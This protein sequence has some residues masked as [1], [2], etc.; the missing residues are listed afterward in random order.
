MTNINNLEIFT[1]DDAV[2]GPDSVLVLQGFNGQEEIQTFLSDLLQTNHPETSQIWRAPRVEL[3]TG[4]CETTIRRKVLRKE[5]P[6]PLDLGDRAKGWVASEVIA[7]KRTR[8]RRWVGEIRKP[9]ALRKNKPKP[10]ARNVAAASP[11]ELAAGNAEVTGATQPV[12][13]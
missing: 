5:F 6:A 3:E 1:T 10:S 12:P 7:W 4:L 8:P 13:A 9:V 2:L 11:A